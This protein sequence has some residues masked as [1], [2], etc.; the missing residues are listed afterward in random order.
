MAFGFLL[1]FSESLTKSI[2]N[3]SGIA[4]MLYKLY[5]ISAPLFVTSLSYLVDYVAV[6]NH[7]SANG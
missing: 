6:F 7:V 4:R 5:S 1:C 3:H 2:Y